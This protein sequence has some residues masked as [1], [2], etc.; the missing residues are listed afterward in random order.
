MRSAANAKKK[1]NYCA[2]ETHFKTGNLVLLGPSESDSEH[3]A[4]GIGHRPPTN[5]IQIGFNNQNQ[6][7]YRAADDIRRIF[8]QIDYHGK[9]NSESTILF[10]KKPHMMNI[11]GHCCRIL[12]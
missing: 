5:F 7:V 4:S 2:Y 6:Q 1:E 10:F 8:R 12:V 11:T 9:F 3:W